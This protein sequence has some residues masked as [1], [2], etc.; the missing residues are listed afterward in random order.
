[1]IKC[2]SWIFTLPRIA[3]LGTLIGCLAYWS[4]AAVAEPLPD[5]RGYEM[6]TPAQNQEAEVYVPFAVGVLNV[7]EGGT[8]TKLPFQASLNG[9]TVAYVGDATIQGIG[10]EGAGLGNEYA[11]KRN[12]SGGWFQ[13]NLQPFGIQS[14]FYQ[15]FSPDLSL[16]ILNAG[17]EEDRSLPLGDSSATAENDTLGGGYADSY[18]RSSGEYRRIFTATPMESFEEFITYGVPKNYPKVQGAIAYAGASANFSELLYELHGA[19]TPNAVDEPGE[20]NL[21][22]RAGQSLNL[23]NVLPSGAS[24]PNATFGAPHLESGRS[25]DFPDFEH[26]ISSDGSRIF[27][28]DL[29]TVVSAEDPAG[30][31]RLF[32][33]ED[34]MGSDARSVQVDASQG[35]GSGGGG[36]FWTATSNGSKVFF[37]DESRLTADS[38]AESDRPDLYEYEIESGRL[39]DLTVDSNVGES[40]DVQGVLGASEDGSYVYF[41]AQGKLASNMNSEG[42]EAIGGENNLYVLKEGSRPVFIATL[43]SRDNSEAIEPG[44]SNGSFGDWQPG[45]GHRTAEVSPDGRSVVFESNNQRVGGYSPEVE[46]TTLEEVY[47]YGTEDNRLVCASCSPSHEPAQ[48]NAESGPE[49]RLGGF[50]PPSWSLTYLPEWMS[51]DGSRVFFDSSEPLVSGD[52]N[53]AQDVYEWERGGTNGCV[54][55]E[56]CVFLLSGGLSE[57]ASWLLGES[58]SGDDV[59]IITRAELTPEDGNEAYDVYDARVDGATSSTPSACSGTGCQGVSPALPTFSTPAS[60]T[61]SGV[62]NFPPPVKTVVKSKKA[63]KKK[64]KTKRKIK[65]KSKRRRRGAKSKGKGLVVGVRGELGRRGR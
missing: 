39:A 11:A 2:T 35:P 63:K 6:V 30:V 57:S 47:V 33:R 9:E 24:E 45:L 51:A 27:W 59:F 25:Q 43:S 65:A 28:T 36:R 60:V 13:E 19:L 49:G 37:T 53:G 31:P 22:V 15:A 34:P 14:A 26:V 10:D 56:G 23:V 44:G 40:A 58:S 48:V 29:N 32:V 41:V 38:M 17:Y 61:F 16:G 20:N 55:V 50:L 64:S 5:A 8:H 54:K 3:A 4:A 46:G 1:M 18:I 21:Y 52:T 12:P 7:G 62:G 42:T